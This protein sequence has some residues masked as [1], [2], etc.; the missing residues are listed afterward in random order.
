MG[1]LFHIVVG[2][3]QNNWI[4]IFSNQLFKSDKTDTLF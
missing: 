4:G 2:N 1:K 3:F